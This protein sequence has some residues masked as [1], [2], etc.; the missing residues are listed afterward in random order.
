MPLMS[1][2]PSAELDSKLDPEEAFLAPPLQFVVV[3]NSRSDPQETQFP[4]GGVE[5]DPEDPGDLVQWGFHRM[6]RQEA[7]VSIAEAAV[8]SGAESGSAPG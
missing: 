8:G 2:A 4:Q 3:R 5:L 1:H 7:P 6:K